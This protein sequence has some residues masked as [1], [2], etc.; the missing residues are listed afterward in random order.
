MCTSW[1]P[2]SRP[3]GLIR[4]GGL[5]YRG[6]T[7]G[8]CLLL[9]GQPLLLQ[10]A[11]ISA[12]EGAAGQRPLLDRAANG[13]PLVHIATPT[14]GG[15]SHNRYD[16][17]N[18]GRAGLVLN[19]SAQKLQRS[20]LAGLIEGNARLKTTG[21]ASVI[22]NE[23]V[24]AHRSD[25]M[26]ML[27]V[28]GQAA[29]VII[30]NP[31][32]LTCD[33]CGFI[34]TPRV[35]LSTGRPQF[36][37]QGAFKGLR[38]EG[39]A[40]QIGPNGADLP[41]QAGL[42]RAAVFELLSRQITVNG[43]VTTPGL[44]KL[45]AGRNDYAWP[46]GLITPLPPTT[47]AADTPRLAIDAALL[48]G[49]T[50]GRIQLIATER[51]AGVQSM[52]H[53]AAHTGELR[54]T[55]DGKLL[56]NRAR[57]AEHLLATSHHA[58][59]E[60]KDTLYAQGDLHLSAGETI[61]LG[62]KA[63]VAAGGT[64]DIKADEIDLNRTASGP[65]ALSAGSEIRLT[66]RTVSAL[67]ARIQSQGA[68]HL[69]SATT[70]TLE[71]GAYL[72]GGDIKLHAGALVNRAALNAKGALALTLKGDLT[73]SGHLKAEGHGG[74]K[75]GGPLINSGTL[76][77]GQTLTL[78]N[79]T[80]GRFGALANNDQ[81]LIHGQQGLSLQAASLHNAGTL[82]SGRGAL[83]LTLGADLTNSGRIEAATTATLRLGGD[84]NNT[85][86][87][88]GVKALTLTGLTG[89]H[90]GAL[91]NTGR[92]ALMQGGERLLI[93]AASLTNAA[94]L[95]AGAGSLSIE[96]T[97]DLTNT[98]L[99]YAR[100]AARYRLDGTLTNTRGDLLAETDLS[101]QGLNGAY[102]TAIH[103][104]SGHIEAITGQLTLKARTL[105]N[106]RAVEPTLGQT[107]KTQTTRRGRATTTV[108]TT[109]ETLT[110]GA[111]PARLL[112]GGDMTIEADTLTN[113]YSQIAANG[114]LT[115][116]ADTVT[117]LGR[118][119]IETVETTV[120]TAHSQRYCATRFFGIC[121]R[122]KTRHWTTRTF[123][124]TS[125]THASDYS[126]ITAGGRLT[127]TVSGYLNNQA[128]RGGAGQIGLASG[129]R[130][131]T[132]PEVAPDTLR[133]RVVSR[134]PLQRALTALL[135]REA[136]FRQTRLPTTPYL[137]ETRSAFINP[138]DYL[139]SDY[140]LN[141]LGNYHQTGGYRPGQALRRFG[142]AYVETRLILDQLFELSGQR[143]LGNA[144]STRAMIKRLYD[145][146]LLARARLG[147][148]FGVALSAAQIA[149]LRHNLIWL[150]AHDV[151]G[152]TVLVPRLYL[153]RPGRANQAGARIRAGAI[154]LSMA[155]LLNTG[156]ITS[157][158]G[159]DLEA[160]EMLINRGGELYAGGDIRLMGGRL[161][162]NQSGQIR[163][164]N[165]T[166]GA[167]HILHDTAKTRDLWDNGYSDRIQQ[168]A[169]IAARGDLKLEAG[170]IRATGAQ[171][172]ADGAVTLRAGQ[173]LTLRAL[174]LARYRRDD[175]QG[176]YDLEAALS[177]EPVRLKAGQGLT[178]SSGGSARLYGV[179]ASAGDDLWV[180]A[181][182]AVT[183]RGCAGPVAPGLQA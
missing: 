160:R 49:M 177:H 24:S 124:T 6:L 37:P 170:V 27:E 59:I 75:L 16:H 5:L 156:A 21:P 14:A 43:P 74:L 134:K 23:V 45:I 41:E 109:R 2:R 50:A 141:R 76:Y 176:G 111:G 133:V 97:G 179:L 20:Q 13:V 118:D 143:Y 7:W 42:S 140:F 175:F 131:L 81:A 40:L 64:L 135:Q 125:A 51:G 72:A 10:A 47:P 173:A 11:E 54:I 18:V 63:R 106:A 110:H 123:N 87:L 153:A 1:L 157:R 79:G 48:G 89:G 107:R 29:S 178:L 86:Q 167:A 88:V 57:A 73:N 82:K 164:Q 36:D 108:V 83:A 149:D 122:R 25:L 121:L 78:Q 114:D 130:A 80:G 8:L 166:L 95:G 33:G 152:E 91:R 32:G 28:H 112:A 4:P 136:L 183:G 137:L 150:E 168:Q 144:V 22:L 19:N 182:G 147:L 38:V 127:G 165:V 128:V 155:G 139:G 12:A 31:N 65:E 181:Q 26:G 60:V 55:A 142:D 52:G 116:K 35:T 115:L 9:G 85:G 62:D 17:F 151:R 104:R 71:G 162:V 119:L 126:T 138:R 67:N 105:T 30:A 90:F 39:G 154:D 148:T 129:A 98:G 77:S 53:M 146:A 66:T 96:L 94:Q 102:A 99:L 158:A 174:A 92:G 161:L 169:R 46:T 159:L 113:R 3:G 180:T 145:Q 171:I 15:L 172:Q 84:L 132:A 44:L 68:L 117:N 58:D 93:R 34:H 56:L 70:L 100:T 69:K 101:V 61:Q 163:G 103:N 120:V